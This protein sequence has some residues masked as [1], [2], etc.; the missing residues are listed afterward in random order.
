M[1]E[2]IK[3]KPM[4]DHFWGKL[5]RR[6][7]LVASRLS[8]SGKAHAGSAKESSGPHMGSLAYREN[9]EAIR[10]GDV[11]AKYTRIV[12]L[13]PGRRVLEIGA[14]EGVLS[15]L[16]ALDKEVVFALDGE[17]PRHAEALRL[18]TI[19]RSRDERFGRCEMIL[20]EFRNRLDLLDQVDTLVAVRMIY[21]LEED[22]QQVFE[23]VAQ[24]VENVVLCGNAHRAAYWAKTKGTGLPRRGFGP[25]DYYA[26]LEGMKSL[27]EGVGYR[28]TTEVSEGDPIVVGTRI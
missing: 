19:W 3:A 24:K 27:L 20:G 4:S 7:R 15:L 11:P 23:K 14:A 17:E 25:Y 22:M 5:R 18:Q 8:G 13:V 21:Y 1:N 6:L 10:N 16:L 2:S 28:I 12:P 26:S 9:R